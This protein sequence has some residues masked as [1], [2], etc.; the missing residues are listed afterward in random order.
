MSYVDKNIRNALA[1]AEEAKNPRPKPLAERMAEMLLELE[2]YG[3][4]V[5]FRAGVAVEEPDACPWCMYNK[6]HHIAMPEGKGGTCRL[7]AICKEI[8]ETIIR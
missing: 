6:P 1:D 4:G 5:V 8:R 7:G 3:S 2:H